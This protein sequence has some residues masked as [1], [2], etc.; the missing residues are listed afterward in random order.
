MGMHVL[1]D[2]CLAHIGTHS[3]FTSISYFLFVPWDNPVCFHSPLLSE[4]L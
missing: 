4:T 3:G 2:C 1:L